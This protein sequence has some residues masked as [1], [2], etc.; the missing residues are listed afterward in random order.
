MTVGTREYSIGE[1]EDLIAAKDYAVTQLGNH[2]ADYSPTWVSQDLTSFSAFSSDW[3]ALQ[4]RYDDAKT[5]ARHWIDTETVVA[6]DIDVEGIDATD[7]YNGILAALNPSYAENTNGPGSIGDLE[8][9]LTAA[10]GT[11]TN[12]SDT[13]QPT[14]DTG[15]APNSWEAYVTGL[16]YKLGFVKPGDMP[17][18]TPGGPGT[19][20]PPLIPTWVKVV[21]GLGLGTW[22]ISNVKDII[23]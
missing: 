11:P 4:S 21:G 5:S 13:P 15:L 6:F 18:G 16:G 1:L 20:D 10:S 8:Q 12:Y 3:A 17:P 9:R 19:G 14:H 2:F 22:L 23:R 7:Q